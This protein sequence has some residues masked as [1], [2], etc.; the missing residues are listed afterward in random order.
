[1]IKILLT[2]SLLAPSIV[3]AATVYKHV[4]P[5]GRISYFDVPAPTGSNAI[6]G[7]E[8]STPSG[9]PADSVAAATAVA[10]TA[11]VVDSIFA[12]CRVEVPESA[13]GILAATERWKAQHAS[14]RAKSDSILAERLTPQ[15]RQRIDA[16]LRQE[17]EKITGQ[18]RQASPLERKR[19]CEGAPGRLAT[20]EMHLA[21]QPSLVRAIMD[22]RSG[23]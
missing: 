22:Y 13:P 1:M 11:V 18:L 8:R 3:E 2:L 17:N 4:G 10:T 5:D 20:P 19:M 14:L 7:A 23:R 9:P 21:G 6:K 16:M 12:F 15:E